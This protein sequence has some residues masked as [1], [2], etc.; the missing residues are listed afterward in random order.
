MNLNKRRRREFKTDY[1][2]RLRLLKGNYL[3]F[4]VRKTNKY[5]ILQIVDSIKAQDK[6]LFS[7][8]TKELLKFDWPEEKKSSLKSLSAAYL[9]GL[10]L[11]KKIINLKKEL[12]LDSG[13]I[14][15]TKASRVYSA[16]KGL[17][18]SRIKIKHNNKIFP[19]E[20]QISGKYMKEDFSSEFK[21]IK[22]KII[23]NDA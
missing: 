9:T 15:N 20:D 18:D 1:K 21:K 23:K 4:V 2:K 17:V 10:L 13:L 14:P 11:G 12:I 8:T 16:V 5:L 19:N 7:S 3:R 22:E 6:I